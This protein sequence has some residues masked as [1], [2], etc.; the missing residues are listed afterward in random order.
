[1]CSIGETFKYDDKTNTIVC[2]PRPVIDSCGFGQVKTYFPDTDSSRCVGEFVEKSNLFLVC[3]L[4]LFISIVF[5][6]VFKLPKKK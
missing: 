2:I 1:M 6:F 3:V 5:V 4:V